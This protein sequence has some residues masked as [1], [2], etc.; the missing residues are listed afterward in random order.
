MAMLLGFVPALI[1]LAAYKNLPA[2]SEANACGP[3]VPP[4]SS[5]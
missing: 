4:G 1:A 2:G 5:V 3:E